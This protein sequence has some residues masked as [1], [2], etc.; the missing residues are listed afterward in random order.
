[1]SQHDGILHFT[2]DGWRFIWI[3]KLPRSSIVQSPACSTT[4]NGADGAELEQLASGGL[5]AQA[6]ASNKESSKITDLIVQSAR[7]ALI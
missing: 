4:F 7:S 1:M 3:P 6:G 2:L 5:Q